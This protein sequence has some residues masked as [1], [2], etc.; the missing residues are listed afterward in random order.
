MTG[1]SPLASFGRKSGRNL[2]TGSESAIT[3]RS[4]SDSAS[5]A[6]SGLVSEAKRKMVSGFTGVPASRSAIPNARS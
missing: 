3:P 5:T 6:I 4:T 2:V 1:A